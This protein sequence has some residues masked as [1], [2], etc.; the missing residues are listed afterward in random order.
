LIFSNKIDEFVKYPRLQPV[1]RQTAK[2]FITFVI[3]IRRFLIPFAIVALVAIIFL[4]IF[5]K[6]SV[7]YSVEVPFTVI[8]AADHLRD[9]HKIRQWMQPFASEK[10]DKLLISPQQLILGNDTLQILQQGFIDMWLR[11]SNGK[12]SLVYSINADALVDK[13]NITRFTLTYNT[14]PWKK[15]TQKN[16]LVEETM[17]NMDALAAYMKD[18]VK[19]YGYNIREVTV[20]DTSFLFS[21]RSVPSA[22]FANETKLL[23]DMLIAEAKKRDA[24]YNGVRIFNWLDNGDGTT[25]LFAGIGVTKRIETSDGDVVSYK[26]MPYQKKLLVADFEGPYKDVMKVYAAMEEYKEDNKRVSMAIPFHKYL[27]DGYG[28]ADTQVVKMRVSFPVF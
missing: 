15:L 4:L 1:N 17:K 19:V 3:M 24:G 18:P 25:S 13:P 27:S 20:T 26:M 11:R 6:N 8:K 28:F 23:F 12:D 5:K 2:R 14:T 16:P 10:G 21:S 9:P 7:T 22:K